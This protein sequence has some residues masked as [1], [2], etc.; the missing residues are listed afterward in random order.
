LG[1]DRDEFIEGLHAVMEVEDD[2]VTRYH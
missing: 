1:V 2:V